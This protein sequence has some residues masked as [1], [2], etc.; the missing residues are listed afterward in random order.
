[1][2]DSPGDREVAYGS[3]TDDKGAG[4]SPRGSA[5]VIQNMLNASKGDE[6]KTNR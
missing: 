5:K 1:M 4:I 6:E 3:D 2:V